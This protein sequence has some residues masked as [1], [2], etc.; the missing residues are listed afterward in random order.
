VLAA[1]DLDKKIRIK[2]NA[3][4]YVIREVLFMK[5]K[6]GKWRPIVYLSK[7]LNETER[8]YVSELRMIDLTFFFF[9]FYFISFPFIFYIGLKVRC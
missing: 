1:L 6:D 7:Y 8:N 3:L 4:D 5:C 2:V 9:L